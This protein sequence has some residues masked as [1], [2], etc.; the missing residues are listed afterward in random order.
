MIRIFHLT[1]SQRNGLYN[2]P[3]LKI[4]QPKAFAWFAYTVASILIEGITMA[5]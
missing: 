1:R 5:L 2:V 4:T 3:P